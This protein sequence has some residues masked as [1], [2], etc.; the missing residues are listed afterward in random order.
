MEEK[1]IPG[2]L[3]YSSPNPDIPGLQDGRL[4]VV[5]GKTTWLP[6]YVGVNSF[7]FG[8]SNVHTL[9][10]SNS[11]SDMRVSQDCTGKR[12]FLYASRTAAGLTEVLERVNKN[13]EDV[14]M[15]LLMNETAHV[16][17]ALHPYR[18]YTVLNGSGNIHVQVNSFSLLWLLS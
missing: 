16:S 11:S 1:T 13:P 6:G 18:G 12:L 5:T 2:N 17:P 3:H 8:G 9:F 10:H 14:D 7:G 15:H 4:Q